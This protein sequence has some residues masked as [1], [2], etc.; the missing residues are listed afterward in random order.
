MSYDHGR[1]VDVNIVSKYVQHVVV[2]CA[3]LGG[4]TIYTNPTT[5]HVAVLQYILDC[6]TPGNTVTWED[7]DGGIHSGAMPF[8]ETGGLV[9]GPSDV[10]WFVLPPGTSLVLRLSVAAQV[11]GHLS[12]DLI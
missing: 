5:K 6:A 11:S 9:A 2:S 10:A 7:S 12:I 3:A 1:L 8:S 4:N